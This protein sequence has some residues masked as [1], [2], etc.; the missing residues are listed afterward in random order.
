M[1]DVRPLKEKIIAAFEE[2]AQLLELQGENPF[3]IRSY[4]NAARSIESL[5]EDIETI[6]AEGRLEDIKGVGKDLA[7]KLD[8]LI[9]TGALPYLDELRAQF[10]P[11]L[12]ELFYI[13]GLGGKRIKQFYDELG[14]Q[15]IADLKAACESNRLAGLK[16]VGAKMEAKLLEGIAFAEQHSGQFHF[17]VAEEAA[18]ALLAYVAGCKAV[19]RVELAGSLRRRK[20][21]I[22]DIDLVASSKHPETVMSH[23]VS[24]PGRKRVTGHG[25]T[26]ASIVLESGISADLRVVADEVFPYTLM[27][28]TGSKEHNVVMRQRAKDRDL[29]LNEYGLHREDETVIPATDEKDIYAALGLPFVPPELRENMGE[30]DLTETPRLITDADVRG[31]IHCHT[32]YSDGRNTLEEMVTAAQAAG[33]EYILITDHSQTAAYAGGL[34][35]DDIL[36]QHEEIDALNQTL[37]GFRILKG[38]ES[39][40][41]G[42][43]ALDYEDEVLRSFDLIVASVHN[44]L[45]MTEEEATARVVRA[46][47]NPYC[48]IIGHPTGRLLLQR[49]GFPLDY[50]RIFD[51]CLAN[52]TALEINANCLRLDLDWRT[53]IKGKRKGVKFCVGPDAHRVNSIDNI[54]YGIGIARKGWLEPQDVLCT[55]TAKELL[56]WRKSR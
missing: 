52:N 48:D 14:I 34:K 11:T 10:P 36:R 18:R 17:H 6:H 12:F 16:G 32:T 53:V 29:K 8:T 33:Y 39:D 28:F 44:K 13:P 23:F 21:V 2:I 42:D 40:I 54:R 20:E 5:D 50:E 45:D 1:S 31:V 7:Q 26:K 3:K 35:P 55:Y 46:I 22:K 30:F 37:H 27:H 47:E 25:D 41:L 38:I 43:G 24:Y 9:T 15:S 4:I 56:A 19:Q 49:K 51:A